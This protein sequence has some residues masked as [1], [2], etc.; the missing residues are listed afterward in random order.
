MVEIKQDFCMQLVQI[1]DT[2]GAELALHYQ[3]KAS[4]VRRERIEALEARLAAAEH[5]HQPKRLKK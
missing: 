4:R 2:C 1:V 5:V 3:Q